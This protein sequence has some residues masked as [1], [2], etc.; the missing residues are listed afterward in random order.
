MYTIIASFDVWLFFYTCYN[1][2]YTWRGFFC[3]FP[4]PLAP[5]AVPLLLSFVPLSTYLAPSSCDRN[6]PPSSQVA[7]KLTL[8]APPFTQLSHPSQ[9]PS[10][11]ATQRLTTTTLGLLR[12]CYAEQG[13]YAI[14]KTSQ[15]L[16]RRFEYI[17]LNCS[18]Q[19]ALKIIISFSNFRQVKY[20]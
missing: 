16:C 19:W 6:R 11:P 2:I 1:Y 13:E 15:H 5:P 18:S 12:S 9:L 20:I 4:V 7:C 8:F 10:T 17:F 14:S 3:P